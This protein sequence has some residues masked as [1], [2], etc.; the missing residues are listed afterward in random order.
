MKDT[1]SGPGVSAIPILPSRL[2]P[3][4]DVL[5]DIGR[6]VD[7]V[8]AGHT[9]FQGIADYL[10]KVDRQGRYY[11]LAAESMDLIRNSGNRA[12]LTP[13]G[14]ALASAAGQQR[15]RLL[16]RAVLQNPVVREVLQSLDAAGRRGLSRDEVTDLIGAIT[17]ATGTTPG[18]RTSTVRSW[19]LD[20]GYATERAGSLVGR[21]IPGEALV[22]V[23]DDLGFPSTTALTEVSP[24]APSGGVTPGTNDVLTYAVD[25]AKRER[26][27][28]AHA[29]LV[30]RMANK[31]RSIG[32]TPRSNALVD[33]A[34]HL[35]GQSYLFEMKSAI[36]SSFHGQVRRGVSQLY[37]YRYRQQLPNS[38]LC[39]VIEIPP[40]RRDAWLA[41]YLVDDR[42]VQICWKASEGNFSCH[43]RSQPLIGMFM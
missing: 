6:T 23:S 21:G 43:S 27:S 5:Q 22:Q 33:L 20:A 16:N 11:R 18:R 24:Q 17:T 35:S 39:L 32:G 9:D 15:E 28:L 30:D 1:L 12:S 4:A 37:E 2:V 3:Q 42:G 31:I 36:T 7:A 29:D 26:A 25:V 13:L 38:V 19:L 41:D 34:T 14:Q 8:A 40:P 10:D